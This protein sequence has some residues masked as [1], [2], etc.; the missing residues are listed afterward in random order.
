MDRDVN[1]RGRISCTWHEKQHLHT[2]LKR[3]DSEVQRVAG[4]GVCLQNV[5]GFTDATSTMPQ[6]PTLRILR[7]VRSKYSVPAKL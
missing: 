3:P 7:T 2:R 4:V 6:H 5:L 1:P